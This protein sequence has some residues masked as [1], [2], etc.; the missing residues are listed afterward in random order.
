VR[1]R[2]WGKAW[3]HL[4]KGGGSFV[5]LGSKTHCYRRVLLCNTCRI[6]PSSDCLPARIVLHKVRGI[7]PPQTSGSPSPRIPGTEDR[8]L[9][10]HYTPA[11]THTCTH[12]C[13]R[14]ERA[15]VHQHPGILS[16]VINMQ[17]WIEGEVEKRRMKQ[18]DTD[19]GEEGGSGGAAV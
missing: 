1:A 9:R 5:A 6:P 3:V 15:K 4:A 12:T 18:T 2:V 14:A 17:K 11:H 13:V 7:R 19:N 16:A 8:P 10:L